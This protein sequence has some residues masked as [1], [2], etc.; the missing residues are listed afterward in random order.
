MKDTVIVGQ[1]LNKGYTRGRPFEEGNSAKRIIRWFNVRSYKELA[2]RYVIKNRFPGFKNETIFK[3][4][5]QENHIKKIILIG[6]KAQELFSFD[7]MMKIIR[8]DELIICGIL[9]PSGLNVKCNGQDKNIKSLIKETIKMKKES[10]QS[11]LIKILKK[12]F[13]TVEEI[14]LKTGLKK[15]SINNYVRYYLKKLGFGVEIS[16]KNGQVAYKIL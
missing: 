3:K 10:K 9:H 5:I 15:S 13:L 12:D 1:E 7:S 2:R 6:K 8:D 14:I 4:F 16:Q 11:I